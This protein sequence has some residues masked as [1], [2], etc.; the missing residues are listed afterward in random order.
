MTSHVSVRLLWHDSGWNGAICRDPA[1]NVWCEAHEHV[2][3]SKDLGLE[4]A[5]AGLRVNT[6]GVAPGCEM[7]IQTFSSERNTIRVWPPDW[8]ANQEVSPV[9]LPLD[10]NSTGMW[11]YEGMW[12]ED[13][14]FKSND[15]RRAI[16]QDFFN[17]VRTGE[18]LAFFYVDERNPMFVDSGERS[19]S[20]VLA[21]ISRITKVGEIHEWEQTDWRGETNMI[22]SVPFQHDFP[23]DGIRF[24]L[25]A[26]LAAV[27]DPGLRADFVVALDGGLRS[28]FRYGS[29]RLSQDRAVAVVERAIVAL[30]RLEASGRIEFSVAAELDWLNRILL[31]LWKERGPYPGFASLL[32]ALG[33]TRGTQIQRDVLPALAAGGK[34]AAAHLFAALDGENVE[35]FNRYALDIADIADEW[36]YL[37]TDDQELARLLIRMELTPDQMGVL[38]DPKQ[39]VRHLVPE[40]AVDLASN[41][42]LICERFVP[43]QD[44]E[45]IGF[46]TVDHALVPHESMSDAPIR[47]PPRDPRR[48]RAL[49]TEVLRDIAADGGTFVASEEA[50]SLAMQRSPE[51]RPCDVPLDRLGHPKVAEV[52][53]ETIER[54]SLDDV[55]QLAL[56]HI[57]A[58]ETRVED[59]LDELVLRPALETEV[60][61]WQAVAERVARQGGSVVV[62]LSEEQQRAL[63]RM[64]RSAVSVLTGAAGT[65]KSTL[66]APL[67]AAIREREGRVPIRALAP[68][69]KAA[70]RLKAVGVDGMTVH[71]ALASAGWYDWD[72][73][74]WREHGTSQISADTLVIDECSMVDI[75]LLGTLFKAVDWHG[76]RRL[77]LVGDHY[78]LPPIGPGRPFFDFI[79]HLED[80]DEDTDE[81]NPYRAR[82]NE[83]SH[84]YR[85]AEGS[86]AIALANGFA[87]Q[88]E[89]DEPLIW[90]SLAKGEDQGDLRVRFWADAQELH[91]LL[92][93]EIE[94]LVTAECE[95]AGLSLSKWQAFNA[96][97]G[98]KDAFGISHWQ[99]LGPVRDSSA[100][101]RKLNAII[102]DRWHGGFKQADR[103]PSGAVKRWPVSFGDEQIT[104]FD[105]VMQIRNEGRLVAYDLVAKQRGKYPAFNGQ[106]GIV[107]GEFPAA[108]HSWRTGQKG[109]VVNIQVQFD[110]APNLRFE[111]YRDGQRGV[112][113]N[114]ELAYAITIHK[115]QGSQFRHVFLVVPQVAATFF[116]RELAYTGLSRAE[117]TLTLF[118]EKD[119]GALMQLR[120]RAA[121]QTPQRSSRLF[122]PRP[123][124]EAYRSGDRRQVSTRGD[125]VRSKSEV[126]IAD[127]LHKYEL[128]GRLSY[129]YEEELSAS[130]G[131]PWDVRLPDFTVRVGGKTHYWEHCG[132]ADDPAYRQRWEEVRRP[133]YVRNGYADQLIETYEEAGAI[134][135]EVIER[136]V[137]LGRIL[138]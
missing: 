29:A 18:S 62:E 133:W 109:K 67:I 6:A 13:G 115:G 106:L 136:E 118:L 97:L 112:N 48:F 77:I 92:L 51:D 117:E 73:G 137:V 124:R 69:G 78:Q 45:L 40:H 24:P 96:T 34:D 116:G 81:A 135:A 53:D 79:M 15:N 70:D 59:V 107:K 38:L 37:S 130:G 72:L 61:D 122:T 2:R 19:P 1:G 31:E 108:N 46:L 71:R 54:F 47:I 42:Y 22:W 5:K 127:V 32:L 36:Q 94:E 21:G 123:G 64:M 8:L 52:I 57:R 76:V 105:K 56:R 23:R 87:R 43:N 126:I 111:Y 28:D 90:S 30:G 27:P 86:R 44:D 120:K 35:E 113:R 132:M 119:I 65:G 60:V 114:L 26:I 138:A 75:S 12:D 63:D 16:A 68:T 102:Q 95:R 125:R 100:G 110:D 58:L 99:I 74:I 20:R 39:R 128:Q 66:L 98:H 85:V 131:D 9:D 88:G 89:A 134:N 104:S 103:F 25:Q 4:V 14:G 17:E 80:A 82:L 84:N 49:L 33:C 50:R 101:T 11:P 3:D 83:L 55:P 41:P 10:K 91:E 129:T 121:A 7:S 93:A